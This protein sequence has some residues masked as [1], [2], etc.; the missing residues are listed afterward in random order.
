MFKKILIIAAAACMLLTG[1]DEEPGE[2]EISI[3]D[4]TPINGY[5]Y[6]LAEDCGEGCIYK[7]GTV[8]WYYDYKHKTSVPFCADPACKHEDK[9]CAAYLPGKVFGYKDKF[10]IAGNEWNDDAKNFIDAD[11]FVLDEL[12]IASQTKREVMRL[13]RRNVHNTYAYGDKLFIALDEQYY[14]DGDYLFASS[15]RVRVYFMVVSLD[16]L[17]VEFMSDCLMDAVNSRINIFGSDGK[18]LFF[19]IEYSTERYEDQPPEDRE[20]FHAER[21]TKHMSY[22]I[23]T[24]EISEIKDWV[25][26]FYLNGCTVYSDGKT[27]FFDRGDK[28]CSLTSDYELPGAPFTPL[29]Y[30]NGKVY[31]DK[32][33][34]KTKEWVLFIFDTETE[35]LSSIFIPGL[36]DMRFVAERENEFIFATHGTYGE[37]A[38]PSEIKTFPKDKLIVSEITP[39]RYNELCKESYDVYLEVAEEEENADI[40]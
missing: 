9:T 22:D 16:T 19:D 1:C 4:I 24:K 38:E 30:S 17:E 34:I 20:D 2:P 11:I 12:D 5:D 14:L 8:M 39:E 21:F 32:Y 28:V 15:D 6:T 13:N 40:N 36:S 26:K 7:S 33:Y 3:P 29:Q 10:V 23:E 27:V 37:N 18:K 35:K 31:S 25:R